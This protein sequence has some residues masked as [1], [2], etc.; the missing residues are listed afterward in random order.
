MSTEDEEQEKGIRK[1]TSGFEITTLFLD[2]G[3]VLLTD[4][5]NRESRQKAARHFGLD[6]MDMEDRHHLM[7]ETYE[8][9]KIKT[10][11]Y[12][13]RMVFYKERSFTPDEFK[14]FMFSQSKAL[15]EMIAFIVALK[16]QYG[17]KII[18]VSNEGRYL[19]ERRI[20]EFGLF[21]FVDFF[22]SSCF[23][24]LRKPDADIFK[25]ALDGSQVAPQCIIYIDDQPMFVRIAQDLGIN[26]IHHTNFNSTVLKLKTFGLVLTGKN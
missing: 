17:L 19:N 24:H 14:T 3:G 26:G 6:H 22:V 20:K 8:L 15:P 16:K 11:E 7:F 18:V 25:L 4:G 10:D 23:A 9:D 2:I 13:Q 12:L 21:E 5:W 1:P